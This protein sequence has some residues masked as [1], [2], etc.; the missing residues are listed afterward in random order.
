MPFT[1]SNIKEKMQR[2]LI[3]NIPKEQL[4]WMDNDDLLDQINRTAEDINEAADLKVEK[5]YQNATAGETNITLD[6]EVHR[7]KKFFY[8]DGNFRSVK[9]VLTNSPATALLSTI[10]LSAAPSGT[11]LVDIKY[12][13]KLATV[14]S[15]TDELDL[16]DLI[17]NDF[18]DLLK[19]RLRCEYGG[20]DMILYQQK[21][22]II[23][24]RVCGKIPPNIE[25]RPHTVFYKTDYNMMDNQ[26]GDENIAFNESTQKY[27]WLGYTSS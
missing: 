19:Q 26:V 23:G 11:P 1:V 15:D 7:I 6:Y 2:W 4:A 8:R 25:I 20:D 18:M 27:Y 16:P 12:L 21:V 10:V 13:R 24:R 17:F 3:L 9:W 14:E 5:F 22:E